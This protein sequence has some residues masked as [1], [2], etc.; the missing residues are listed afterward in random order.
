V[1]KED[2]HEFRLGFWE[3]MLQYLASNSHP[4]PRPGQRPKIP[5]SPEDTAASRVAVY[6]PYDKQLAREATEHSGE[7]FKWIG[8]QLTAAWRG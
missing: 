8:S 1:E 3:N 4:W 2:R 7:L 6:R 5:G